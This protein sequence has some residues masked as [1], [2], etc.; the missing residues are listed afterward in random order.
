M[1]EKSIAN[2][3]DIDNEFCVLAGLNSVEMW[4]C[5]MWV[6]CFTPT[7]YRWMKIN[8]S[9]LLRPIL[10]PAGTLHMTDMTDMTLPCRVALACA[11]LHSGPIKSKQNSIIAFSLCSTR[12]SWEK[13]KKKIKNQKPPSNA[14]NPNPEL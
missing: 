7:E 9:H 2:N 1:G 8:S 10:Q 5:G 4:K 11:A 12:L 14:K 3:V 13:K 6:E